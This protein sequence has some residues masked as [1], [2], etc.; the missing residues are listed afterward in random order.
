MNR[1]EK[2]KAHQDMSK[3]ILNKET[4]IAEEINVQINNFYKEKKENRNWNELF[5]TIKDLMYISLKQSY[6]T[7]LQDLNDIYNVGF[8]IP[9]KISNKEIDKYT[10]KKDKK[11]LS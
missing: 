9:N 6:K 7:T 10:Y 5:T 3:E 8:V 1:K 2:I 4:D 11:S